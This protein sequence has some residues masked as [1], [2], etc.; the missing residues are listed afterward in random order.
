M[1]WA[2]PVAHCLVVGEYY[3]EGIGI[4]WN[5]SAENEAGRADC[6]HDEEVFREGLMMRKE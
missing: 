3:M 6:G 4:G 5:G 1:G 2:T